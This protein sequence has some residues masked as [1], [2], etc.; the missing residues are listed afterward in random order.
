MVF[1][2]DVMISIFWNKVNHD[3]KD[4]KNMFQQ[5]YINNTC[6]KHI[7]IKQKEYLHMHHHR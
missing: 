6:Y 3:N 2:K 1:E 5:K 7:E 4:I